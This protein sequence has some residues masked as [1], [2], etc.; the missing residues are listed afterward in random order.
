MDLQISMLAIFLVYLTLLYISI[1]HSFLVVRL[2][3]IPC[4]CLLLCLFLNYLHLF[5]IY[6]FLVSI[7]VCTVGGAEMSNGV[8]TKVIKL[9][10]QLSLSVMQVPEIEL[11]SPFDHVSPRDGTQDIRCG[12]NHLYLSNHHLALHLFFFLDW[13]LRYSKFGIL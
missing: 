11:E 12:G 5:T 7:C 9:W 13:H 2:R 8:H 1:I 4:P 3:C 10:G 6:F